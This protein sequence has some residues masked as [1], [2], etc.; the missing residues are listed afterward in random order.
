MGDR[1]TPVKIRV[2]ITIDGDRAT[3]DLSG[4]DPQAIGAINST[5]SMA[6][7]ALVVA[8]KAIFPH[9]PASEGIYNA[10]DVVNPEGLVTNARFP[11][12]D[13]RRLRHLLRGDLRLCLRLLPPDAA[14]SARWPAPGT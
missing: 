2:E 6:Q 1:K 11:R 14:R 5:R 4:S 9:V 12:A 10:I 13:L 3:Y 8:T 7:S